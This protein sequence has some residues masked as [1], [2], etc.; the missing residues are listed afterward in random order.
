MG[1]DLIAARMPNPRRFSGSSLRS[2]PFGAFF[3]V[4]EPE[5][6]LPESSMMD[7]LSIGHAGIRLS[8]LTGLL[9]QP[10][11]RPKKQRDVGA[12]RVCNPHL[13]LGH[14][15]QPSVR[16]QPG[17][18]EKNHWPSNCDDTGPTWT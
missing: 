6:A 11:P 5:G 12:G 10:Y 18:V 2:T 1:A 4:P 17:G 7:R 15:E 16:A 13:L 8:S 9:L 14:E 3:P